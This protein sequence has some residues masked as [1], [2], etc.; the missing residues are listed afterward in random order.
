MTQNSLYNTAARWALLI[1]L[2][3]LPLTGC[4]PAASSSDASSAPSSALPLADSGAPIATAPPV[5]SL[6]PAAPIPVGHLRNRSDNYAFADQAYAVNR[7]FADAPPDYQYDYD[8]AQPWVWRG[9]NGAMRV[10]EALP[11]GGD[12]YYYYEP[13]SDYPYLV[14]DPEYSYGYDNGEL[15]VIYDS[16]GRALPDSEFEARR[17][18]ASRFYARGHGLYAGWRQQP[19]QP[20]AQP[21]WV[22]RRNEYAAEQQRWADDQRADADWQAYHRAHEQQEQDQWAAERARR[23]AEAA[24]FALSINDAQAAQRD[25]EEAQRAQQHAQ[26]APQPQ[27][28]AVPFGGPRQP[29]GDHG[30]PGPAPA[31]PVPAGAVNGPPG[32]PNGGFDHRDHP[33][34]AG[35]Q[36]AR[37]PAGPPND[38]AQRHDHQGAGVQPSGPAN[39]PAGDNHRQERATPGAGPT[40]PVG[41]PHREGVVQPTPPPHAAFDPRQPPHGPAGA[42]AGRDLTVHPA[43]GLHPA[44]VEAHGAAPAAKA[45]EAKPSPQ[46]KPAADAAGGK[47][48][49]ELRR[50]HRQNDGK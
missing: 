50:E 20:V 11:G 44:G 37:A 28:G 10:A 31:G 47:T 24:A 39:G 13:G 2:A 18:Y 30:Q 9:D 45:A 35:P 7:A 26:S 27:G 6:P 48:L 12:R 34:A 33:A 25:R 46:A 29:G 36:P 17:D 49:E 5:S 41:P 43:A 19:H 14:R 23:A 40:Q 42:P 3:A 38:G 21:N 4:K 32:P 15:V 8:G 1:G 16:H 22:Q